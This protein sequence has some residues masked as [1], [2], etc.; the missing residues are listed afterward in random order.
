MNLEL[1]GKP[2]PDRHGFFLEATDDHQPMSF[3][4]PEP[5]AIAALGFDIHG[6][7]LLERKVN[8]HLPDVWRACRCAYAQ[9]LENHGMAAAPLILASTHFRP[10]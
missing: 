7:E 2:I 5:V 9:A 3:I 6:G 1:H 10:I 8:D 4:L